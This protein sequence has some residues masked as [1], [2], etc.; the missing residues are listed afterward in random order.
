LADAELDQLFTLYRSLLTE[1][2][3]KVSP[4]FHKAWQKA[5]TVLLPKELEESMIAVNQLMER[6]AMSQ[7]DLNEMLAANEPMRDILIRN[8]SALERSIEG[9]KLL[10]KALNQRIRQT[11][12]KS[13]KRPKQKTSRI[14]KKQ[15]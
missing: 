5:E 1:M 13:R 8:I 3:G 9:M 6:S 12:R 10:T 15:S 11:Q 14:L 7:Q 4:A 2:A